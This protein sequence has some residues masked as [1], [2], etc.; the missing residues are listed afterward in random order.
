MDPD[1]ICAVGNIIK[2]GCF[3]ST[4]VRGNVMFKTF[5]VIEI[6]RD[7][8]RVVQFRCG[9]SDENPFGDSDVICNHHFSAL[10]KYFERYKRQVHCCDPMNKHV[11]RLSGNRPISL[12][13]SDLMFK[14]WKI[15]LIPGYMLCRNCEQN[16]KHR[17]PSE[18]STSE[19]ELNELIS[20]DTEQQSPFK[21]PV[22]PMESV[23]SCLASIK[24]NPLEIEEISKLPVKRKIDFVNEMS[25]QVKKKFA[26]ELADAC[27]IQLVSQPIQNLSVHDYY[28][29][30][31]QLKEKCLSASYREKISILTLAPE[32][33][34]QQE[35]AN[36]F[37][38]PLSM[39]KK[40]IKTR[41]L[42][43]L[44]G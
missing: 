12:K 36:F 15:R 27:S 28:T 19:D 7:T 32:K 22:K 37:G 16:L 3:K 9:L 10:F 8:L 33:W 25:E 38:V 11:P 35:T 6:N 43:G 13:F 42:K 17:A 24:M 18:S 20:L 26:G 14:K 2:D 29:F 30:L 21:T 31:L 4:F 39:V 34:T 23:N 1:F 41:R 44:F 40:S 5:P